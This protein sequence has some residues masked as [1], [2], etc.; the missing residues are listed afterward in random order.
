MKIKLPIK[1]IIVTNTQQV[2]VTEEGYR[3]I[4]ANLANQVVSKFEKHERIPMVFVATGAAMFWADL[5]R[6][7]SRR[8]YHNLDCGYMDVTSYGESNISQGVLSSTDPSVDVKNRR[9]LLVEDI[10]DTGLTLEY[11]IKRLYDLGAVDVVVVALVKKRGTLN[12]SVDFGRATLLIGE[13]I[14]DV[15]VVGLGMDGHSVMVGGNIGRMYPE[16][17]PITWLEQQ[18]SVKLPE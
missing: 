9:V 2:L 5:G 14:P 4:V 3:R 8:G 10:V 16:L 18:L 12:P 1:E 7:L 17:V 15:F 13:S 11:V 6:E